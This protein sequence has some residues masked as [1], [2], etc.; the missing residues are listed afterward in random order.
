MTHNE[1]ASRKFIV[2]TSAKDES[3]YIERTILSMLEQTVLPEVWVIVDDGSRDRTLQI[4]QHY[5]QR[6]G[7]I[8]P[9]IVRRGEDR[10]PGSAE[11]R[12]FYVGYE[13]V[14][15]EACDYLVKLDADLEFPPNYFE[16]I[17]AEFERDPLLG[18]ASGAYVEA[19]NG[20]MRLVK[21]PEYHAAGASKVIRRECFLDIGGFPLSPGWDTADEIKAHARGWQ[22]RHCADIRFLHLRPEGS[23]IGMLRTC[24][25]HGRMYH[26]CG[27]GVPFLVLKGI[28]RIA[29][30]KPFFVGGIALFCGYVCA[31][32]RRQPMLVSK[33]E[34]KSYR[35]L[36]KMQ[37]SRSVTHMSRLWRPV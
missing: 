34:A 7:W 21:M 22:T 19:R 5:A 4:I 14:C 1:P 15:Q 23:A 27:G 32:V 9:I 36:L 25:N 18:I 8:V 11:I 33:E 6:Y 10:R 24:F 2:I 20:V 31:A 17:F 35:K 12:A 26:A 30:G 28:R 37:V 16:R 29:V 13:R 3:Q